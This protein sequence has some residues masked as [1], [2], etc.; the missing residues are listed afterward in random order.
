MQVS[1]VPEWGNAPMR[2]LREPAGWRGRHHRNKLIAAA[3]KPRRQGN[4]GKKGAHMLFV[5]EP[6]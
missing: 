4:W 5:M 3:A 6:T 2:R 1:L